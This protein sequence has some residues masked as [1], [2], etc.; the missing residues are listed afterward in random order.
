M[1]TLAELAEQYEELDLRYINLQCNDPTC[2]SRIWDYNPVIVAWG[3]VNGGKSTLLNLL[4]PNLDT[5]YFA[6]KDIQETAALKQYE[7]ENCTWL[8]IPEFDTYSFPLSVEN[9]SVKQPDTILF[10]H[11]LNKDLEA[12]EITSLKM[13]CELFGELAS[14]HIILVLSKIDDNQN[15]D[16][17]EKQQHCILKQWQEKLG[18]EPKC[19]LISS[20]YYQDGRGKNIDCLIQNSNIDKLSEHIKVLNGAKNSMIAVRTQKLI[21]EKQ[22]LRKELSLLHSKFLVLEIEMIKK[23]HDRLKPL[24]KT[25]L[26]LRYNLSVI[27][28]KYRELNEERSL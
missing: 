22:I 1:E 3:L 15:P 13:L 20:K 6:E 4:S 10:V 2:H 27:A 25:I 24:Y 11:Q 18:F 12:S 21:Y 26:E 16:D 17:I 14:K 8:D 28:G 9:A 7:S 23:M 5:L 19:F